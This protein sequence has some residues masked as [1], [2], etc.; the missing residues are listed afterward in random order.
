VVQNGRWRMAYTIPTVLECQDNTVPSD[1][2]MRLPRTQKRGG[3][4]EGDIPR[5]AITLGSADALE[6]LMRKIG[7]DDSEIG[8]DS[9]NAQ[10][11]IHVYASNGTDRFASTFNAGA[12]IP[13][14]VAWWGNDSETVPTILTRLQHYDVIIHSCEGNEFCNNSHCAAGT[15][16]S[17]KSSNAMK[18]LQ[19]YADQYGRVFMSHF[20]HTW[21]EYNP[22]SSWSGLLS[23]TVS[24]SPCGGSGQPA[25]HAGTLPDR[26]C[27]ATDHS[28][29]STIDQTFGKGRSL[30]S[31]LATPA[32]CGGVCT[33]ATGSPALGFMR[34]TTVRNS[35]TALADSAHGERWVY[36]DQGSPVQYAA[37][38][39]PI[40]AMPRDQ[41]GRIVFSDLH[42]SAGSTSRAGTGTCPA[43]PGNCAANTCNA[44]CCTNMGGVCNGGNTQ[45]NFGPTQGC[46]FPSGCSSTLT[47]QEKALIFMMFD[48]SACVGIIIQ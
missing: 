9:T 12:T 41:C 36:L 39:T 6:C 30:A 23:W 7:I 4:G 21:M 24:P 8:T 29:C 48:L 43:S 31:W 26:N 14:A 32:V 46:P 11:R 47:P 3:V 27:N 17:N 38:N 19:Q 16:P 35:A 10:A 5:I 34:E 18:A 22:D 28:D 42:V 15:F 33:A 37:S 40:T 2:T 1:I 45:C 44:T 13:G 25:C 20:H